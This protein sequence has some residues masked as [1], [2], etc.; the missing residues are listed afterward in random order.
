MKRIILLLILI[1]LPL[2]AYDFKV[3]V[4]WDEM[5]MTGDAE[6]ILQYYHNGKVEAVRGNLTKPSTDGNV[7]VNRT[8]SGGSEEFIIDNSRGKLFNIWVV[9]SVMDE[10]FATKE[11]YL[12]LSNA[13]VVVWVE[14][15]INKQTYQVS[16]PPGA[17]GLV[18]RAGA[19]VDG[20]FFDFTEMFQQ[21]R[22][23][24][25]AMVDAVTGRPLP[26]VN[27]VVKDRRTGETAG[28]GKTDEAGM[29]TQKFDYGQYDVLFSKKGYL[30]S[31]HEFTMDLTELPVAM[32]FALSP[33]VKEF[34]IVLTWGAFPKDLDAHLSGPRPGDGQFHIWWRHKEMIAGKDFLDVD[35]QDSYGPETITIYKPAR[36]VYHYAVHNY[37]GRNRSN[38]QELS[39][40]YAHVDVYADGRLQASFDIPRGRYGNVWYVFDIDP[41][42]RIKPVNHLYDEDNSAQVFH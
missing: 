23:Y 22:I 17:P 15:N 30:S 34:R 40:S 14:D 42:L 9:N 29:F 13:K 31:K 35:D 6:A 19:I 16:I 4:K 1:I 20:Q 18:F 32:N 7:Q 10:D 39:Y 27:V 11:D 37:S 28:L 38:S 3:T 12:T 24:Q 36:G 8:F 41:N 5:A 25:V 26:D 33:I 21:Q 2:Y